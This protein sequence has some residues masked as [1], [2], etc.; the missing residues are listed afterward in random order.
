MRTFMREMNCPSVLGSSA[1]QGQSP[2]FR[3]LLT[4]RQSRRLTSGGKAVILHIVIL[5]CL[6]VVFVGNPSLC[7]AQASPQVLKV[8][9]PSWWVRHSVN[10]VRLL[11]RGRNLLGARVQPA[12]PGI[13]F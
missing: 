7:F 9:P 1:N 8:D 12:E 4:A 10:P 3:G 6:G 13:R 2:E 11:I 5:L